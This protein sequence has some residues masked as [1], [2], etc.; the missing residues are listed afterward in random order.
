MISAIMLGLFLL[1]ML[2]GMPVSIAIMLATIIGMLI[3]GYDLLAVPQ[4]MGAATKSSFLLAIPFFILAANLMNA[5]GI[6]QRIFDFATALAGR[7]RGGLAQVNVVASMIFAGISG[8]AVADAAG[9]GTIE[10]KA[11]KDSGYSLE[12]AAAITLASATIGPIIPPSVM[13]LIYAI[14]ANVS[15]AAMFLAGI[16]P[17][18]LIGLILMITIYIQVTLG[19]QDCPPPVKFSLKRL[20]KTSK[21]GVLSLLAPIPRFY[22]G[23]VLYKNV[24]LFCH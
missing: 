7:L 6:T 10:I 12:F 23:M 4:F 18:F 22:H 3:G 11:M 15:P 9:L 5:L 14:L 13:M 16:L 17:G 20:I 21:D 1:L 24:L 8:A 19:L 2:I